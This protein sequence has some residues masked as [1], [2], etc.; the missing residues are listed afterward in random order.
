[1]RHNRRSKN[2]HKELDHWKAFETSG[3]GEFFCLFLVR[4]FLHANASTAAKPLF[5]GYQSCAREK[6]RILG[7]EVLIGEKRFL[8]QRT[9]EISK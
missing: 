7:I 4:V 1:M 5:S 6:A 9:T 2:I 8:H 3:S